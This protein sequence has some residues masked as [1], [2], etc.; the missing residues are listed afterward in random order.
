MEIAPIDALLIFII[1]AGGIAGMA[2]GAVRLVVPFAMIL[3]A[4]SLAH[5]YPD[6]SARFQMASPSR[7]FLFVLFLCLVG[8]I[9]FGFLA[10]AIQGAVQLSGLAPLNRILGS[11]LGLIIGAFTAGAV[12]WLVQRYGSLQ[13]RSLFTT[14]ALAPALSEFFDL[15][16]AFT[17]RLFPV[18]ARNEPWWK[19]PWW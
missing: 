13:A 9:M 11:S 4:I 12:L 17:E 7:T 8:L 19:R 18:I 15:V 3:A 14:S 5:D 6:L 16:V 2:I 10:R 1:A